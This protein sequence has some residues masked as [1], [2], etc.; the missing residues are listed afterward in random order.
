MDHVNPSELRSAEEIICLMSKLTRVESLR[1]WHIPPWL[2]FSVP[3]ACPPLKK[4]ILYREVP[5]TG[6]RTMESLCYLATACPELTQLL[7]SVNTATLPP[8]LSHLTVYKNNNSP[9]HFR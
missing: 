8:L 1:L 5:A 2:Q 9:G 6:Q 4:L 7:I 3:A